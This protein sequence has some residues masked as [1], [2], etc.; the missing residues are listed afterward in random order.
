[1][2]FAGRLHNSDDLN[3]VLLSGLAQFQ[4]VHIHPFLDGNGRS[5]RLLSTLCLYQ[6]GYDFKRLFTISEYCDRDRGQYYKAIQS[7]RNNN[8]DM[9]HWLEYFTV[10]LSTQMQEV[11]NKGEVAI[12][13]DLILSVVKEKKGLKDR[14]LSVLRYL[15][16][17]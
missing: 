4:L 17:A 6:S 8:M 14:H 9:T 5:A 12:K 15:F 7:V 1:M 10:G 3:P 13:Q 11:K 16:S 2:S